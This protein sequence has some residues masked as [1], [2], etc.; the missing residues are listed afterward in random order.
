MCVCVCVCVC[1]CACACECACLVGACDNDQRGKFKSYVGL[2]AFY[3]MFITSKKSGPISGT[4]YDHTVVD[5]C[6]ILLVSAHK[7]M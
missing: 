7:N 5:F 4:L 1:V 2:F 6:I 3:F